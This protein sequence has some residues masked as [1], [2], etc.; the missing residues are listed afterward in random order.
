MGISRD[1]I[2]KIII[3]YLQD[4]TVYQV[5]GFSHV[6]ERVVV[7]KRMIWCTKIL[8]SIPAL[9]EVLILK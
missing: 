2:I 3:V 9:I 5:E 7:S 4:R 1:I 6:H 8:R